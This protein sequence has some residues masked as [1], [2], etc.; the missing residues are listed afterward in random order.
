MQSSKRTLRSHE[1]PINGAS[2]L[3]LGTTSNTSTTLS[4][5]TNTAT[6]GTG[7]LSANTG[8]TI[9]QQSN[10]SN[11]TDRMMNTS[12]QL[13]SGGGGSVIGSAGG[14]GIGNVQVTLGTPGN[15]GN[16]GI[17]TTTSMTLSGGAGG[18][19]LAE[20]ELDLNFSLQYPHFIKRDGNR[21]VCIIKLICLCLCL[22][23][24]VS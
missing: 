8:L 20:T 10:S 23:F 24:H 3:Q 7:N 14:G 16:S 4:G 9:M 1:I 21:C 2:L 22:F 5:T 13:S 11:V 15:I 6:G 18:V 17:G 19:P 12:S